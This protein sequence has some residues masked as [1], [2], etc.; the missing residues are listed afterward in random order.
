MVKD[1]NRREEG[2]GQREAGLLETIDTLV[3]HINEERTWF[4]I[5]VATSILAAPITLFFTLFLLLHR[6][7]LIFIFRL[8]PSVGIIAIM[9]FAVILIVA[10]LWLVVGIKEFKF[11]SKWNSRFRQ[12]F[13]LKEQLDK[14]LR[15]EFGE[16]EQ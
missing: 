12:Y 3:Y 5:L 6:R 2:E 7:L 11:L 14:E 1:M 4:N 10:S 8:D 16:A 15:R 9:Y 13:S